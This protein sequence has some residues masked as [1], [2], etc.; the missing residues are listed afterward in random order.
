MRGAIPQ[1]PQYG[2]MEW[3]SVKK[4]QGKLRFTLLETKSW[5][6]TCASVVEEMTTEIFKLAQSV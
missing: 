1:V 3:C 6:E 4:A 2:L 5:L